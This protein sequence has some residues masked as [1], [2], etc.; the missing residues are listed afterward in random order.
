MCIITRNSQGGASLLMEHGG[1]QMPG[2][3][4]G[5]AGPE[6]NMQPLMNVLSSPNEGGPQSDI[7]R[8]M[9]MSMSSMRGPAS[10]LGA[11]SEAGDKRAADEEL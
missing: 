10:E 11:R 3:S 5:G 2:L 1:V 4:P 8:L 6:W 9:T 7:A